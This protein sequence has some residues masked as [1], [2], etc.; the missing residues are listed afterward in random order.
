VGPAAP[1]RA[2]GERYVELDDDAGGGSGLSRGAHVEHRTFGA[3]IILAVEGA[4]DPTVTVKFSGHE[5]K[6]I[7]ARFLR[8]AGR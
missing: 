2:A 5:P 8:L 3:G 4:S 7:K 6:A 1:A